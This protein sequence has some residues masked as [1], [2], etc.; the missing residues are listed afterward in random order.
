[1][2]VDFCKRESEREGSRTHLAQLV[3]LANTS[4]CEICPKAEHAAQRPLTSAN[5]LP[6][7]SMNAYK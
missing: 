7:I 6:R 4:Q 2:S 1:M 3:L 5:E